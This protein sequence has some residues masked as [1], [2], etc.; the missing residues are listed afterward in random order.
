[1]CDARAAMEDRGPLAR[2]TGDLLD[3]IAS[4]RLAPGAGSVA[5]ISAALAAAVSESVARL[6][7]DAAGDAGEAAEKAAALRE[8]LV[9]LA[10]ANAAAYDE[11]TRSLGRE[12]PDDPVRDAR[13]GSDLALAAY[14]PL[15]IAEVAADAAELAAVLAEGANPDVRAD[16]VVAA[17]LGEAAARGAA[18]LVRINLGVSPDDERIGVA[19]AHAE[20][21]EKARARALRHT[22]RE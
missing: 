19:E 20:A 1:M 13:L 21:A 11:A 3:E 16:A 8:R 4:E 2:Q 18:H 7:G 22:A 6:S 12:V 10:D 17:C 15:S 5:A 14:T 9:L